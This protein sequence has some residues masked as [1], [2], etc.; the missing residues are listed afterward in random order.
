MYSTRYSVSERLSKND[1]SL[2]KEDGVCQIPV[3]KD[4]C[5][6]WKKGKIRRFVKL[7]F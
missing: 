2:R 5:I 4:Q 6:L 7:V 3:F 1:E